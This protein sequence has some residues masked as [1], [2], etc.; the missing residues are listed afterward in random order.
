MTVETGKLIT[1]QFDEIAASISMGINEINPD[2]VQK[3]TVT[4]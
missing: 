3:L 1:L 4:A 2:A